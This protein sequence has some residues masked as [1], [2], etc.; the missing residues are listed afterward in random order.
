MKRNIRVRAGR[1]TPRVSSRELRAARKDLEDI[2]L[3][4]DASSIVATTDAAGKI[5]SVNDKFSEVSGY[6]REFL[7]GKTHQVINSGHHPKEFFRELW[8]TIEPS[9][10][11]KPA[12]STR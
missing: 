6:S 2:K 12:V 4:L 7:L 3:A 9:Q 5:L 10:K 8:S 11:P 1:A